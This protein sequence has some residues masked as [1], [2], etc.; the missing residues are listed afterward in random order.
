M[1]FD[2]ENILSCLGM[3]AGEKDK[4]HFASG[5]GQNWPPSSLRTTNN[6][7]GLC[8]PRKCLIFLSALRPRRFPVDDLRVHGSRRLGGG[9]Q[10]ELRGARAAAR[11]SADS[12]NGM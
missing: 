11:R 5:K 1:A 2:H 3:A 4:M 9:P 12:E 7:F 10:V 6:A 8:R